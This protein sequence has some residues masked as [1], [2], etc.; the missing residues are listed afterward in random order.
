MI[1]KRIIPVFVSALFLLSACSGGGSES[2]SSAPVYNNAHYSSPNSTHSDESSEST[3]VSEPAQT[4]DSSS[5]NTDI[6][7]SSGSVSEE[8]VSEG[9]IKE[10][11]FAPI[12]DIHQ[13][14]R[15]NSFEEN[16][17]FGHFCAA[18][19]GSYFVDLNDGFLYFSDH[20]GNKKTVLEDYVRAL[21]Y[22]DG[23]L[24]YI[25]GTKQE[26]QANEY[27]Y[28][29]S[30]WRLD[31]VS[32]EEVCLIDAPENMSLNVNEY[33]IFCNPNGGGLARYDFDGKE[34]ERLADENQSVYFIGNKLH[35]RKNGKTVLYD[36]DTKEESDFPEDM[37]LFSCVGDRV[38]CAAENDQWTKLVMNLSTGE[39]GI[40]PQSAAFAF[41]VCNGELY[42]ADNDSLYRVD[43]EKV[44]YE[45][46]I[47]YPQG[48]PVYFYALH[49]GGERLYAVMCNQSNNSRYAVVNTDSGELNYPEEQ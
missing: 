2:E 44:R 1:H 22:Y 21:N 48:S 15:G 49:S 13:I 9:S 40:F 3:T 26:F 36:L 11:A 18:E 38:I 31:P 23:Y 45:S 39:M 30:V 4:A 43:L 12:N 25:K 41:A 20:D 24:Y 27:F 34:T 16:I 35:L 29:G 17:G 28:A 14:A 33:G 10:N 8:P 5:T 32:G 6:S 47:S 37:I 7:V 19:D 46:V 42:A